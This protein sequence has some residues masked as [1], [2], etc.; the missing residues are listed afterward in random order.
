M[1]DP[2]G[3]ATA[4]ADSPK[5]YRT[6]VEAVTFV[7]HPD[8][9]HPTDTK[10]DPLSRCTMALTEFHRAYRAATRKHVP[11]LTYERLHPAVMWFT[12]PA[13]D[14]SAP[15]EPAGLLMLDNL[16][17]PV[18]DTEP[19]DVDTLR[20]IAHVTTRADAGDPFMVYGERR[21]EAEIEAR[22][23]GRARE[24]II[25]AGIAAEVLLGALLGIAM[26]EEHLAGRLTVEGAADVLSADL[27]SRI[28]T[29]YS[30]RF[31]GNWKLDAVPMSRWDTDIADIRNRVVHAG[32]R[33]EKYEAQ[34]GLK[35]LAALEKFVGDRLA[36]RWKTY[37]RTAWLF[38]GTPGFLRR[39]KAKLRAAEEWMDRDGSDL[40]TWIREYQAWRENVT[41]LVHRR[42]RR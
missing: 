32:F 4:F 24:S 8:D 13:F 41:E 12:K 42:R 38:L 30:Q 35:A 19:L 39:G 10:P 9:F 14:S 29:H 33:P 36:V 1:G 25:Q 16:N 28:K 27:T 18:P 6:V 11:E 15:L 37:P 22:T 2:E 20:K 34:A 7:A 40:L 26:W 23:N 17:I 31:G 21:L 5:P 3:I